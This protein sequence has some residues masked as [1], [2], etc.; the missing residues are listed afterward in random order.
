MDDL[1]LTTP[2][3][4]EGPSSAFARFLT[5]M[6]DLAATGVCRRYSASNAHVIIP[7]KD[8]VA[9]ASRANEAPIKHF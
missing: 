2:G 4:D 6:R 7:V 5:L 8:L 3:R 9:N 1:S